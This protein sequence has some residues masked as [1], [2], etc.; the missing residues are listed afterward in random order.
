MIVGSLQHDAGPGANLGGEERFLSVAGWEQRD[1]RRGDC[2]EL[3]LLERA[4]QREGR[5]WPPRRIGRIVLG[6]SVNPDTVF[7]D[8]DVGAIRIDRSSEFRQ[9]LLEPRLGLGRRAIDQA[10]G[11]LCD[12]MLERRPFSQRDCSGSE[13]SSEID[14]GERKENGRHIKEQAKPLR[15]GFRGNVRARELAR[16]SSK[17]FPV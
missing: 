11:L 4:R 5:L 15:R 16:V 3:D 14:E 7:A 6:P 17:G 10:R 12:Q 1:V 9:G 8:H 2:V 13:P